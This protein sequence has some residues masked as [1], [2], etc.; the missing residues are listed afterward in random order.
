MQG[1]LDALDRRVLVCDGAM[2]TVLYARGVFL[3]RSFD[4]LN[5]SAPDLVA[6]VHREYVRAGADVI[7]T[8]TFGAN[9]I[10][11]TTFGLA[12]QV[13]AINSKGAR[14]ARRV[15]R[16][17]AWVAG[18]IGPLG[19]RIEPWGRTTVADA[20][21]VFGE[22]AAALVEGGVD[23]FILETFGSIAELTAAIRAVRAVSPLPIVAQLTTVEDGSAPD[24]TPVERFPGAIEQAGADVI[25]LNCSVGPAAMLDTIERMTRVYAGRLAAQPN[26]GR[27]RDVDGRNLYLSSPEYMASYARR[28]VAA[29]VRLVGG[30]CGTTPEHTRQ[31]AE[32]VRRSAPVTRHAASARVTPAAEATPATPT[33]T[34][35]PSS[36]LA[37]SLAS[38]TFA[39]VVEMAAPRGL[40][41]E[42]AVAQARRFCDLGAVAVN[43]PDYPRSG[44]RASALALAA[45]L[46]QHGIETLL[47]YTCRDRTLAGM[48]SD[49]VAAHVMGIRN[50]LATTGS[51]SRQGNFPDVTSTYELD[52]IGL[53]NMTSRLN[54][55]RD[56]AGEPLDGATQFHV[57]ATINPFA[58]EPDVEWQRLERKI[59]AGAGFI[60][61][62][63][64]LDPEALEPVFARLARLGLP[65]LAGVAALEHARHAEWLSSEVVGVRASEAILDRL[66]R[67]ADPAAE[68]AAVTTE[69]MAWLRGRVQG[70]VLTWL[71]GSA[72]TAEQ[73]IM[74]AGTGA[75]GDRSALHGATHE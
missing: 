15:A 38:G 24:G 60:M 47:H 7:E 27:P 62:P 21:A 51:P 41:V 33:G 3:N 42:A 39:L 55:G 46:E 5:L 69:I 14:L 59:A 48:Q 11:L 35:P 16:D 66:R 63:P 72:A 58:A 52:A 75:D 4:E 19:V 67:A 50:L 43:V 17:R 74:D 64:V 32:A 12:D 53:L 18:S 13:A 1:F 54:A 20:E 57:G 10:K 22:Q 37:R 49:L 56:V 25:G 23:L 26:A 68:A 8:N 45:L 9:R 61:T 30:C 36:D 29:G 40:D 6:E 65:V 28:F 31:I 70:L 2:G 44:A 34:P 73:R 71:H